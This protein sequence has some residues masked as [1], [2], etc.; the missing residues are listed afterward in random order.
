MFITSHK[1]VIFR[2]AAESVRN[3]EFYPADPLKE[4]WEKVD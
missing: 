1:E 4:G 3:L 2:K